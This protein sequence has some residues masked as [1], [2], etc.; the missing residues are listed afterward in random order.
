VTATTTTTYLTD[1][2]HRSCR[3]RIPWDFPDSRSHFAEL[4]YSGRQRHRGRITAYNGRPWRATLA[5]VA[6]LLPPLPLPL[7]PPLP[8][9]LLLLLP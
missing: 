6:L 9:L 4:G 1:V 7:L 5:A 3:F 2:P 8:L